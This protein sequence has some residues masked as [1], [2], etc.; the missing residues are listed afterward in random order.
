MDQLQ[1]Y[2]GFIPREIVMLNQI[3]DFARFESQRVAAFRRRAHWAYE[4]A[5]EWQRQEF[6]KF[7]I[8]MMGPTLE[9]VEDRR[10]IAG[11]FYDQG[12]FYLSKDGYQFINGL[13]RKAIMPLFANVLK[14]TLRPIYSSTVSLSSMFYVIMFTY[15]SR[16]KG[17]GQ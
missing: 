9:R 4:N 10:M 12:L 5:S 7:L 14:G 6:N 2:T 11:I 13:A 1:F 17:F 8:A 15:R 16:K 3:R